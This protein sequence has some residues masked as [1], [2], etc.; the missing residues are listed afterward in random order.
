MRVELVLFSDWF[1]V[2]LPGLPPSHKQTF[3][4]QIRSQKVGSITNRCSG[5]EPAPNQ[6]KSSLSGKCLK[7]FV[8]TLKNDPYILSFLPKSNTL[9]SQTF[10]AINFRE[11]FCLTVDPQQRV[12]ACPWHL[13]LLLFIYNKEKTRTVVSSSATSPLPWKN[14]FL[15]Q[16]R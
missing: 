6:R 1:F 5:N 3:Q 12:E 7:L 16:F 9:G 8:G 14:S 4:I 13:I 15:F 10:L 11:E 2:W